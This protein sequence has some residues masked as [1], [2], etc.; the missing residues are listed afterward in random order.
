MENK[1]TNNDNEKIF[2]SFLNKTIILSSKD[3]YRR[4]MNISNNEVSSNIYDEEYTRDIF[5]ILSSSIVENVELNIELSTAIKSLSAI[6]QSVIFLLYN[7]G[8]THAETA[9]ILK[10]WRESVDRIKKRALNKMKKKMGGISDE[11]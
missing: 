6:E 1:R 5:D 3:Y 9:E 10:I 8:L 2:D 4:N 7:E 11:K